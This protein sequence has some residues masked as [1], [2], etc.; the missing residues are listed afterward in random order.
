MPQTVRGY[1]EDHGDGIVGSWYCRVAG[2]TCVVPAHIVPQEGNAG[3]TLE[4]GAERGRTVGRA[5]RNAIQPTRRRSRSPDRAAMEER[6][7]EAERRKKEEAARRR[8]EAKEQ[9]E[10][11]LNK[12]LKEGE[13]PWTEV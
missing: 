5:D 2:Q 11:E 1:F 4:T 10:A 3:Y 8:K 9:R 13:E 12:D 7:R 6:R